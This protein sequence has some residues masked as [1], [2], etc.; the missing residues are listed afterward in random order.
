MQLVPTPFPKDL[1]L[2]SPLLPGD[3]SLASEARWAPRRHHLEMLEADVPGA[4]L[5]MGAGS[6]VEAST[7]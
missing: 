6:W 7:F 2:P 4:T 5:N 1:C 3:L